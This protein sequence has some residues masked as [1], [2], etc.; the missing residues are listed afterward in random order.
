MMT[1]PI[2]SLSTLF[3]QL[4]MSGQQEDIDMF[5]EQHQL[6]KNE[7]LAEARFWTPSQAGFLREGLLQDAN[8]AE[9]IDDLNARLHG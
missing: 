8:W 7:S 9:V 6:E 5:I 3:E 4:G 1:E 2:Y